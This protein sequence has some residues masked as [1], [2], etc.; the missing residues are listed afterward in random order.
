MTQDAAKKKHVRAYAAEHG[1]SYQQALQRLSS[2]G[3]L[4][5]VNATESA[6]GCMG[7]HDML[8]CPCEGC[9]PEKFTQWLHE[10]APLLAAAREAGD[11]TVF[12]MSREQVDDLV[13]QMPEFGQL[14][15]ALSGPAQKRLRYEWELARDGEWP[16]AWEFAMRVRERW[17]DLVLPLERDTV[18]AV[19][20]DMV[21]GSEYPLA[22]QMESGYEVDLDFN[23]PADPDVLLDEADELAALAANLKA[24]EQMI[25]GHLQGG[26]QSAADALT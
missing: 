25:R 7:D 15:A 10:R 4:R 11:T 24:L 12:D 16:D 18:R 5:G 21:H 8:V 23:E 14:G 20:A 9:E 1:L 3:S 6:A 19:I 2:D 22:A 13:E 17:Q 26:T